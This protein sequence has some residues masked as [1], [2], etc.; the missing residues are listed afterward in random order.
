MDEL[1]RTVASLA[2]IT[3]A[4]AS[5]LSVGVSY[6]V[7]EIVGPLRDRRRVLWVLAINFVVDVAYA[8]V[9]PRVRVA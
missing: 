2:T 9:D 4:V 7:Q 8:W 5:M 3:F 6:T 1:H